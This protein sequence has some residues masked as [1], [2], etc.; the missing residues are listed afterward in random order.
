MEYFCYV[1]SIFLV[2]SQWAGLCL[3][4][5]KKPGLGW[6]LGEL[7][8]GFYQQPWGAASWKCT[9]IILSMDVLRGSVNSDPRSM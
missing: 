2:S 9:E 6:I 3:W 1:G 4:G 5:P 7:W 8:V